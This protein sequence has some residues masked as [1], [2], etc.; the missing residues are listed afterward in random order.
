[1]SIK[2]KLF[3]VVTDT[4]ITV[5]HLNKADRLSCSFMEKLN[6]ICR[7][8]RN[9]KEYILSCPNDVT[10]WR[11][12]TY[13]TKEPETIEWIDTFK[14]DDIFFDIGANIGLYSIY[15]AKKGVNVIAFEP[16]SQN[17]ALINKNVYLNKCDNRV[18]CLN[19]A[20]SDK[21]CFDYLYIPVLREG[22]ALNNFEEAIDW[23]YKKFK[24]DYKQGVISFSLDS[25]LS[26]HLKH[27]PAHIKIDVDGIEPKII[28]G[29]EKTLKDSRVKSLSIE[30]N[31]ALKE[32]VEIINI[33]KSNGFSLLH[34][35]HAEM[36]EGGKFSSCFNYLF[37]RKTA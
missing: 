16:E 6:P 18:I 31:E 19:I 34:K 33:L 8:V 35:K 10:R 11:V 4:F 25:L 13:F 5:F 28:K 27:F 26:R 32:H 17:Y 15:A 14:E 1:M 22:G 20:L 3:D 12:E 30:I 37:V 36:F 29:A 23:E 24:P 9:G 7:I 21:D 2:R